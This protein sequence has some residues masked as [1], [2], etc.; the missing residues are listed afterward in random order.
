[1]YV[2]A[3]LI[4]IV[5]EHLFMTGNH[6]LYSSISLSHTSVPSDSSGRSI[7]FYPGSSTVMCVNIS[8]TQ[9]GAVVTLD[10]G[11]DEGVL[12]MNPNATISLFVNDCKSNTI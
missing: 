2:S 3:I 7:I 9:D 8:V 11:N 6:H 5:N 10:S 4:N 1:M 12:L